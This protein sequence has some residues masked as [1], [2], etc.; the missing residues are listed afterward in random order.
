MTGSLTRNTTKRSRNAARLREF[1]VVEIGALLRDYVPDDRLYFGL[2]V[3]AR[4]VA[5]GDDL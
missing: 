4:L 3:D 1:G 2:T 5:K